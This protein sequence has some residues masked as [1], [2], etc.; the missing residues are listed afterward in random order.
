M[1]HQTRTVGL[2]YSS[3]LII[4]EVLAAV[5]AIRVCGTTGRDKKVHWPDHWSCG[6]DRR[7]VVLCTAW[8]VAQD[9]H[10]TAR[11]DMVLRL[12]RLSDWLSGK[13]AHTD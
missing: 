12:G 1:A 3:A 5:G 2:G 9:T 8:S 7:W 6:K 10:S 11:G 13:K 4:S